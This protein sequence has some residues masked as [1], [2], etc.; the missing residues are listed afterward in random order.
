MVDAV[1]TKTAP[2][3]VTVEYLG[4]HCFATDAGEVVEVLNFVL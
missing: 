2:V 4:S 1:K 3:P